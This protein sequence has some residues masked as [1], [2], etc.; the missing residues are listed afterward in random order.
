MDRVREEGVER[1][2]SRAELANTAVNPSIAEGVEQDS[3]ADGS[4]VSKADLAAEAAMVEVLRAER[5]DDGVL[6]E[7][8]G[9]VSDAGTGGR[10]WLLD[11]IDG[12]VAFVGGGEHWGTHVALEV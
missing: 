3:K 6:S 5:P 12:T 7:E 4:P 2:L 1:A 9:L 10:R 8:A 11:P